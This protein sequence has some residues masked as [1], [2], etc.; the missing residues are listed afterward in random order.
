MRPNARRP[1]TRRTKPSWARPPT[2]DDEGGDAGPGSGSA[3]APTPRLALTKAPSLREDAAA[4][5]GAT[6]KRV[7]EAKIETR[8]TPRAA[9]AAAARTGP[10]LLDHAGA[11]IGHI[12]ADLT[13]IAFLAAAMVG[14]II[15]LS[16]VLA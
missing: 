16:F 6:P 12:R 3:P 9:R 10:S 7:A 1:V 14:V 11:N 8:A 13:R 2:P 5:V 15:A 4:R